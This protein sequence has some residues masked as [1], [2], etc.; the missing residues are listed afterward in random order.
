MP[1]PDYPDDFAW[2]I[3][4]KGN[5]VA[6]WR[7]RTKVLGPCHELQWWTKKIGPWLRIT[8][9][10]DVMVTHQFFGSTVFGLVRSSVD[11]PQMAWYKMEALV[12]EHC[13]KGL[14]DGINLKQ[15]ALNS[16]AS[17]LE[18]MERR[19]RRRRHGKG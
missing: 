2:V 4:T 15:V 6:R 12:G 5:F 7:Y 18:E 3:A 17:D 11:T 16:L 19:D 14:D 1:R 9:T 10:R 8:G 13:L